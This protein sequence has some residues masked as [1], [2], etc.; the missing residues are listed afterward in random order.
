MG[1]LGKKIEM[2]FEDEGTFTWCIGSVTEYDP[3]KNQYTAF[4]S[5]D[6]TTMYFNADDKDYSVFSINQLEHLKH[7]HH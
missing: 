5:S 1:I 2:E 3:K 7:E 4:F 6:N